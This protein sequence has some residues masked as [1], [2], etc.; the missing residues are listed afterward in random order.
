MGTGRFDSMNLMM[1]HFATRR[2][3][4][5]AVVGGTLGMAGFTSTR[6]KKKKK[7]RPPSCPSGRERLPNGTCAVPCAVAG[8]SLPGGC[9]C[10]VPNT[11][12]K[13]YRISYAPLCT[14][15]EQDC[16][17]TSQCPLG[18]HCQEVPCDGGNTRCHAVCA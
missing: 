9:R 6:G 1:A 7:K 15:L 4:L 8:D 2:R 14:E 16:D 11:E 10:S 13:K 12:G 5:A 18:E 3:A 17:N